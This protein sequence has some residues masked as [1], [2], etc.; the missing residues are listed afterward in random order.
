MKNLQNIKLNIL[1][2]NDDGIHSQGLI[3][4][5]EK[6]ADIATVYVAAPASEKSGASSSLTIGLPIT[7]VEVKVPYAEKAYAIGG[8]PADCGKIAFDVLY[9]DVD[10]D[11]IVSGINR[12]PNIGCDIFYSGT[13]GAA[14]EAFAVGLPSLAL[15]VDD[16]DANY[17]FASVAEVVVKF[18]KWWQGENLLPKTLFNLNFP[19]V[20]DEEKFMF[21]KHGLRLYSN[22][23]QKAE[24]KD[25]EVYIMAGTPTDKLTDPG[26]DVYWHQQGYITATPLIDIMTDFSVLQYLDSSAVVDVLKKD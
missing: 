11:L 9:K 15:S 10:F 3:Q 12:G 8:T 5:V 26:A 18:I 2:S 14:F 19:S 4:L 13:V 24:S 25:G 6:L 1:V 17:N 7:A 20:F 21:T 23:F 16:Y 22:M